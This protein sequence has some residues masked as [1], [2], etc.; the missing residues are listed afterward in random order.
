MT[1]ALAYVFLQILRVYCLAPSSH[2][3][4]AQ[5]PQLEREQRQCVPHDLRQMPGACLL[6]TDLTIK[7]S[8]EMPQQRRN[9]EPPLVALLPVA[10]GV[11]LRPT[12][13]DL[14]D[15]P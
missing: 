15:F 8:G 1:Q 6:I 9:A 11:F 4:R 14:G 10:V 3:I 2:I 12:P 5:P 7:P 13:V